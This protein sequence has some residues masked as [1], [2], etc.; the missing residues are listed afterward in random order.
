MLEQEGELWHPHLSATV[1]HIL[2]YV[3][4][5]VGDFMCKQDMSNCLV[6]AMVK[7]MRKSFDK[8]RERATWPCQIIHNDLMGP[9]TPPTFVQRH[10]YIMIVLDDYSRYLQVF[11]L[12]SKTEAPT[13]MNEALR[14]L[15]A[16]FPGPGQFDLLRS[17][18]GTE[19]TGEQMTE[20]LENMVSFQKNLNLIV[21]SIMELLNE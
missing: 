1:L 4:K 14:F 9:V 3:A 11:I 21:M 20:V 17:D 6:C 2:K 19:F 8:E 12:K 7:L 10:K 13:G 5:D 15:Q 18:L 16:Q